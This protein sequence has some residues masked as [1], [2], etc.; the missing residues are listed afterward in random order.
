MTVFN[1][2]SIN[3]DYFYEVPHIPAEGETIAAKM[4]RSGLGGKGANQSVAAAL[5]GANVTH[6]GAIGEDGGWTVE[7]LNGHGIDVS[8]V[9]TVATPTAHAVITVDP[10]GENTIVLFT[11]ANMEQS[12]DRISAALASGKPNDTLLL[13]NET[14]HQVF[15]A[16]GAREKGMRVVYSAAPFSVDAVT[17]ML[18]H[19]SMLVLNEVEAEQLTAALGEINVPDLIVTRG[20]KGASWETAGADPITVPAFSVTAVD[21]TGAG[22]C[23]IGSVAASIDGG[24]APEAAL[25]YAAAASAIQVSRPGTSDA[26]PKRAEVLA[27]LNRT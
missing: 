4:H 3:V 23:F 16:R 7:R 25:R 20:S 18:P 8:H 12:E 2:G 1:L 26:M 15:A 10:A 6:I 5:A 24:E 21:T 14:S 13:Q 17:A 22:D 11:G 27:F 19:L 9:A